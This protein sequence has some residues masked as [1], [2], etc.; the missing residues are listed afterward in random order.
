MT[1]DVDALSEEIGNGG[2]DKEAGF[3]LEV[4]S[5]G[6]FPFSHKTRSLNPSFL[7]LSITPINQKWSYI[8]SGRPPYLE[9]VATLGF[10][11]PDD[12]D[13]GEPVFALTGG[14]EFRY[15][16]DDKPIIAHASAAIKS[17]GK[18]RCRLNTSG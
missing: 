1:F 4:G 3:T 15:P 11:T 13:T 16:C 12:P 7:E 5:T 2:T 18:G 17:L 14:F 6:L 10:T 9:V 8:L